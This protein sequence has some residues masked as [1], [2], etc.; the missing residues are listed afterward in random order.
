MS[1]LIKHNKQGGLG[2]YKTPAGQKPAGLRGVG[3]DDILANASLDHRILQARSH[4]EQ[5]DDILRLDRDRSPHLHLT[6]PEL[7][8]ELLPD[9]LAESGLNSLSD[10]H[11]ARQQLAAYLRERR[12]AVAKNTLTG[13]LNVLVDYCTVA[14]SFGFRAIPVSQESVRVYLSSY[15]DRTS[16]QSQH[17]KA[18]KSS[19]LETRSR[20]IRRLFRSLGMLTEADDFSL[21]QETRSLASRMREQNGYQGA[22]NAT[23]ISLDDIRDLT[24]LVLKSKDIVLL[25][26]LM[27]I[28]VAWDGLMR[29]SE[30]TRL[31]VE[32]LREIPKFRAGESQKSQDQCEWYIVKS[33]T[34]QEARGAIAAISNET[35]QLLRLWFQASGVNSGYIFRPFK[36]NRTLKTESD[37]G[38]LILSDAQ[39]DR[40]FKEMHQLLASQLGIPI[41]KNEFKQSELFLSRWRKPKLWSSH[42]CRVGGTEELVLA[43]ADMEAIVKRGRWTNADMPR[44]YAQGVRGSELSDSMVTGMGAA[45]LPDDFR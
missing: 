24:E 9:A 30:V 42:S 41:G 1:N 11:S 26:N 18:V 43:G 22:S 3:I 23:G 38:N 39:V 19:T 15:P 7:A 14:M 17:N 2:L 37:Q 6:S 32:H 27:L 40:I 34:D 36:K 21:T 10:I 44:R 45:G 33:K 16:Y 12:G 25:R 8:A 31:Q 29:R 4:P 13:E 20:I 28:R 5:A 35:L